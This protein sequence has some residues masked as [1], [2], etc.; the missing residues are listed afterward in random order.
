MVEVLGVVL[1]LLVVAAVAWAVWMGIE[2]AR[3]GIEPRDSSKSSSSSSTD[4]WQAGANVGRALF[5]S[6]GTKSCRSCG[7]KIPLHAGKCPHCHEK[8]EYYRSILDHLDS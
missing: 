2:A 5:G 8:T 1:I 3:T 7:K 6:K 4:N